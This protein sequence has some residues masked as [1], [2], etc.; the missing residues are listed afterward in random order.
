MVQSTSRMLQPP[1]YVNPNAL[2]PAPK[3]MAGPWFGT[4]EK[5]KTNQACSGAGWL[6]ATEWP[7]GDDLRRQ[8]GVFLGVV[9]ISPDG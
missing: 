6:D 7:G 9:E 1:P 3:G 5:I 4:D 2:R 8:D